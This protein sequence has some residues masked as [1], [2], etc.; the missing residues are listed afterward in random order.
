MFLIT[1]IRDIVF[2]ID[3]PALSPPPPH[4]RRTTR[5]QKGFHDKSDRPDK[6]DSSDHPRQ[7]PS[8]QKNISVIF[9]HFLFLLFR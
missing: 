7:A 3:F 6:S 5:H 9:V 4:V 1:P 8:T 2:G